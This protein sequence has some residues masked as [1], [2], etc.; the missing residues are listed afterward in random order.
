MVTAGE[1]CGTLNK[2]LANLWREKKENEMV[3][4][5]TKFTAAAVL[6]T[7]THTPQQEMIV[8][9]HSRSKST[10]K[11]KG[12]PRKSYVAPQSFRK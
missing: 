9:S 8:E 11:E 4:V 10:V 1:V 3:K 12:Y 6:H 2:Q 5:R 7:Y